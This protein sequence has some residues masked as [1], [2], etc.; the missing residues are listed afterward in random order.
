MKD[1]LDRKEL[2][3]QIVTHDLQRLREP[4]VIIVLGGK[5]SYDTVIEMFVAKNLCKKT[6]FVGKGS[7]AE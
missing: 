7:S 5:S 1:F 6:K 3:R 2:Y 4:D